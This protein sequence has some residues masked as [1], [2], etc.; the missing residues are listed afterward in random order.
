MK[1][2]NYI[3]RLEMILGY[4]T[5]IIKPITA[6]N[7]NKNSRNQ[8]WPLFGTEL[9]KNNNNNL[10]T[11]IYKYI[12][13]KKDFC[14]LSFL[15]PCESELKEGGKIKNTIKED[16]KK[17]LVFQLI[18]KCFTK[19]GNYELF[20][21]LYLLPARSLYY[22]NAYEELFNIIKDNTEY[23]FNN[24]ETIKKYY[25][26]KINYELNISNKK[27]PKTEEIKNLEKP[28]IP[29]IIKEFY[30]ESNSSKNNNGFC[31][32]I[33]PGEIIREKFELLVRTKYLDLIRIEYFTK[34]FIL[35][36]N[37]LDQY[38]NEN[39]EKNLLNKRKNRDINIKETYDYKEKAIKIDILNTD[40]QIEE[41]DKISKINKK[42]NSN[43]KKLI[44]EDGMIEEAEVI[45]SLVR[46]IFIN[47]KPL[48]N[49]IGAE[50]KIKQSSKS[51]P[52]YIYDYVDKR[53][54]VDFFDIIRFKQNERILQK[55]DIVMSID[56]QYY[57]DNY[58]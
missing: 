3:K 9:I 39:K 6:S 16:N 57:P 49:R 38:L 46:Y 51:Y 35:E 12:S 41:N 15:L 47:K 27:N 52:E 10:K 58:N 23:S 50:L 20:K 43:N 56:S 28:E 22:K 29:Q 30:R 8:K 32:E 45:N 40:Y 36:E 4:P 13:F 1:D 53:N 7:D 31:P 26:D 54:Y 25:I 24:M 5:L 55:N 37:E 21:Y 44:I 33:I 34:Y 18:S 2:S 17:A 42:L 11:E 14:I 19:G 48:K